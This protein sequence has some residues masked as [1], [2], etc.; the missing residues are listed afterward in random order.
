MKKILYLSSHS[1]IKKSNDCSYDV[2]VH[3]IPIAR[4]KSLNDAISMFLRLTKARKSKK[5]GVDVKNQ[6]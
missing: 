2:I 3:K 5:G 4:Q 1:Y 6:F